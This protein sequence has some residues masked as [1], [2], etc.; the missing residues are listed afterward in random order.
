[1]NHEKLFYLIIAACVKAHRT[2][3]NLTQ[4]QLALALNTSNVAILKIEKG[5][6]KLTLYQQHLLDK[7]FQ[8][9]EENECIPKSTRSKK[10][11]NQP[12][13]T[14]SNSKKPMSNKTKP[15]RRLKRK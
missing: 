7:L 5:I 15:L 2:K 11:K 12:S 13:K 8:E 3:Y 9:L 6:Q 10:K 4:K 1:M 14:S